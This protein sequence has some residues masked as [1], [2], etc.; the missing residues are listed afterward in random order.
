MKLS[1]KIQF[2]KNKMAFVGFT[3]L[4]KYTPVDQV[5]E[6]GDHALVFLFQPFQG[7]EIQAIGSFLSRNAA[8]GHVLVQI[9]LEAIVLL[10]NA[11]FFVDVVVSD[12]AQ[13][14]R[15]MWKLFGVTSKKPYCPHV[16]DETRSLYFVSDFPHLIKNLW[17]WIV[18]R[19]HVQVLKN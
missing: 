8:T 16:V 7:H 13:W 2:D 5:N 11:G 6:P 14:N 1:P 9:L 4:G 10:E 12:G 18:G 17:Q 19:D 15:R 3:D